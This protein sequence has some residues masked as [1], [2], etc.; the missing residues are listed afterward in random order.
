M[1]RV[2]YRYIIGQVMMDPSVKHPEDVSGR[3]L[4]SV[5]REKIAQLYG[6][7]GNAQLGST[8]VLKLYDGEKGTEIFIFRCLR[9]AE[10]GVRYALSTISII[11]RAVLILRTLAV[12]GS[13]RT[14][15]ATAADL[16]SRAVG[17][18]VLL[19]EEEKE[20]K[21]RS[22]QVMLHNSFN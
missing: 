18:D 19:S 21:N 14:C 10:E 15:M 9:E 22:L 16:F 20:E 11:K 6:E 13:S 5:V 12:C 17:A 7:V 3:S 8:L 1:V 4:L 2:K